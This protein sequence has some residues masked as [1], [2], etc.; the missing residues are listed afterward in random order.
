[1]KLGFIKGSNL[2]EDEESKIPSKSLMLQD[3]FQIYLFHQAFPQY[4]T[5]SI[6]N[7]RVGLKT[8]SDMN[9][10]MNKIS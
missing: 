5:V 8:E 3:L 6:K 4:P 1:M 2:P 10:I 7:E 9:Q